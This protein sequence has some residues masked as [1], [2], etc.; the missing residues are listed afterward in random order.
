[1]ELETV[2][3]QEPKAQLATVQEAAKA[4]GVTERTIY[5]LIERGDLPSVKVGR[6]YR[7]NL[8]AFISRGGTQW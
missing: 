4:L 8:E 2:P 6:V 3:K 7:V 5:N 1:M